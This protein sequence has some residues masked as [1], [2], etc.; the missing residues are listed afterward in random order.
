MCVGFVQGTSKSSKKNQ[1]IGISLKEEEEEDKE[2]QEEATE[3][4]TAAAMTE[5]PQVGP[6][7]CFRFEKRLLI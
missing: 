6:G 2:D 4:I 7:I 3:D 5:L 1:K